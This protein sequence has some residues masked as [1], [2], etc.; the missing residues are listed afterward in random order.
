M[1]AEPRTLTTG[2]I[3]LRVAS[4]DLRGVSMVDWLWLV[5]IVV[6]IIVAVRAF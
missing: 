1:V 5:V 2:R 6:I 4:R 3:V